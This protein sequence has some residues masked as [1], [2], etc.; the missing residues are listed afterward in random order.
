MASQE[1]AAAMQRVESILTRRPEVGLHDDEPATAR[2]QGGARVASSHA[3]GTLLLT[4]MP[5]ELGG[6]GDQVTPG[7]LF[8][9][10]LASCLATRIAMGAAAAGFELTLLEVLAGSRSDARG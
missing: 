8:R 6:T 3:N 7:W 4:D 9:A 1:I 2:W 5:T 10:G